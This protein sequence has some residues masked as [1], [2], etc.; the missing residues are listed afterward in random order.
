VRSALTLLLLFVLAACSRREP[1]A[2]PAQTTA[3]ASTSANINNAATAPSDTPPASA[4]S[5][6]TASN[7]PTP[8]GEQLFLKNCATCH[9][10]N[11]SGVPFLQPAIRGS[12]WLSSDDPQPLLSLIL[13]GS[14]ALGEAAAGAYENDMA[15]FSHLSD[16]EIAA[17]A[18]HARSRFATPPPSKPVTVGDVATA[19]SRPGM[20][21]AGK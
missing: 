18:T 16:A 1:A 12:A 14:V 17:L 21:W 4:A 2:P 9:M 8:N 20:P 3:T 19:R 11:G 10:A 13:R 6:V 15:P 5:A 7:V